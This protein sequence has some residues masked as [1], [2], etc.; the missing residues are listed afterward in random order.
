[1]G[2]TLKIIILDPLRIF[3]HI[4]CSLKDPNS[5]LKSVFEACLKASVPK[6]LEGIKKKR[7]DMEGICLL[8]L[9]VAP[10]SPHGK[11]RTPKKTLINLE[12]HFEKRQK[13]PYLHRFASLF[14]NDLAF[15]FLYWLS[16]VGPKVRAKSL[17]PISLLYIYIY[18]LIYIYIYIY[19][20][21]IIGLFIYNF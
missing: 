12:T 15:P 7:E 19:I 1:M 20:L 5:V 3:Q 18:V 11:K 9:S 6:K 10:S 17:S 16:F 2:L 8:T 21:I 13:K 14:F 4:K